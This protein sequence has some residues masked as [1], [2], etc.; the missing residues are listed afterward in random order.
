[1]S[2][3]S[4]EMFNREVTMFNKQESYPRTYLSM[5]LSTGLRLG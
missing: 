5:V 2:K 3:F 1:M 4:L